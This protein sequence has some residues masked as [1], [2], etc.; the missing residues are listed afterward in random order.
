M[1]DREP[2]SLLHNLLRIS[3]LSNLL[4]IPNSRSETLHWLVAIRGNVA[5]ALLCVSLGA[6]LVPGDASG[7]IFYIIAICLAF[8]LTSLIYNRI[9]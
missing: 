9:S 2:Y 8:V 3:R 6:L 5:L 4:T 1:T 7:N